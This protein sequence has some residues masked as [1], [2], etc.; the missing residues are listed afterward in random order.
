[1]IY[2]NP[3]NLEHLLREL[4]NNAQT[5]SVLGFT[6]GENEK[7][8][9]GST[10]NVWHLETASSTRFRSTFTFNVLAAKS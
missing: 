5:E 7:T 4:Y 1:M 2:L 10:G 9:E 8:T 6:D 3:N